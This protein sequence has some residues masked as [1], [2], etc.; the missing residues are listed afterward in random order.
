MYLTP[1]PPS[2]SLVL[3]QSVLVSTVMQEVMRTLWDNY[4]Q[5]Y[6]VLVTHS[7]ID[8]YLAPF[9]CYIGNNLIKERTTVTTLT[10]WIKKLKL[11]F[12]HRAS[13]EF[14]SNVVLTSLFYLIESLSTKTM[15]SI[16]SKSL[17][18]ARNFRVHKGANT[19]SHCPR[20]KFH[21]SHQT[22]SLSEISHS[23][24]PFCMVLWDHK[25]DHA[26]RS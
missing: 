8:I 2:F 6:W 10:W 22:I 20:K 23:Q 12:R 3:R 18:L 11:R 7:S 1:L 5:W 17:H 4:S 15:R 24:Y 14:V 25:N 9:M 21:L 16:F 26:N 13:V 19:L